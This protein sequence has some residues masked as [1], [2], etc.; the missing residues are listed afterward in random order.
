MPRIRCP[1]KKKVKGTYSRS[2]TMRYL[3]YHGVL[4]K[5]SGGLTKKDLMLND[6]GEVVS[7]KRHQ[8]GKRV[9]KMPTVRA[10]FEQNKGKIREHLS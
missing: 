1:G 2:R 4:S 9:Y 10:A 8:V 6:R 7:R 3:V 5:T